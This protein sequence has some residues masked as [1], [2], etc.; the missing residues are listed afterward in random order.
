MEMSGQCHGPAILPPEKD[1]MLLTEQDA[2]G[3]P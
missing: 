2:M 1:R 3:V